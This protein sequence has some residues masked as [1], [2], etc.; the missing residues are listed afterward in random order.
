MSG[1]IK[2][3]W[4]TVYGPHHEL[5]AYITRDGDVYGVV[6][7]DHIDAS[8]NDHMNTNEN[9]NDASGNAT[10]STHRSQGEEDVMCEIVGYL[11]VVEGRWV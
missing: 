1:T 4:L 3:V 5:T 11:N 2:G 8:G 6:E 9:D 10:V 7:D